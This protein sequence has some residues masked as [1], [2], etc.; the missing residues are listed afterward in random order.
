MF[1]TDIVSITDI[2]TLISYEYILTYL[3]TYNKKTS[4]TVEIKVNEI[5]LLVV[6]I[7]ETQILIII[8]Y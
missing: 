6:L 7:N 5:S 8:Y 1:Y 2:S 3:T 4:Q